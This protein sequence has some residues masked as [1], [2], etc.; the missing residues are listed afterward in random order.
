MVEQVED[1]HP[2]N[3]FLL[4]CIVDPQPITPLITGGPHLSFPSHHIVH[5]LSVLC[6]K[7][8]SLVL[9]FHD[10]TWE[11]GLHSNGAR[12]RI[13][14]IHFMYRDRI[15]P[16]I[17]EHPT[18]PLGGSAVCINGIRRDLAKNVVGLSSLSGHRPERSRHGEGDR[19]GNQQ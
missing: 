3:R 5:P 18:D 4:P 12:C 6:F 8:T 16:M 2:S 9:V 13:L 10:I 11:G 14:F 15:V 19:T 17:L 1:F 7:V